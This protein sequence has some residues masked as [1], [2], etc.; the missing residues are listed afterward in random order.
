MKIMN[1][2]IF[3]DLTTAEQVNA[4]IAESKTYDGL[5]VDMNNAK[6]RKF[7]KDKA[8]EINQLLKKVDRKRIDVAKEFKVSVESEAKLITEKLELANLPFTALIDE[9]KAERKKILDAE[10]AVADA[11]A[12]ASQYLIDHEFGLL[13]NGKFD[14]DMLELAVEQLE[15]DEKLKTEAIEGEKNARLKAESDAKHAAEQAEIKR[16]KDV[17]DA[18]SAEI[19]RQKQEVLRVD[20]E[21]KKREANTA[22]LARVNNEILSAIVSNIN[23]DDDT[24]KAIIKLIANNRIPHVKINY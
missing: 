12:A 23:I 11:K 16:V 8:D 22:H 24:A 2:D 9:H 14:A 18:K 13:M 10:K 3:K 19:D 21:R 17:E 4:L 15:R 5:Y 7:V 6:E 20:I 1:I